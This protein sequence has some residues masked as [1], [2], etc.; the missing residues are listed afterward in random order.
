MVGRTITQACVTDV[1]YRESVTLR[2]VQHW[3]R[4]RTYVEKGRARKDHDEE[5]TLR[6][7]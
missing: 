3:E 6:S 5:D 2:D 7:G 1:Y 4:Q